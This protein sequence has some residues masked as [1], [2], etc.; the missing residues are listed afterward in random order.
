MIATVLLLG[1]LLAAQT[2]GFHAFLSTL[3]SLPVGERSAT[4]ATFLHGRPLPLVEDDSVLTFVWFGHA[5]SVYVNGALQEG[6][7]HPDK[8]ER[9]RCS[10]DSGLFYRRYTVPPDAMLEYQLVIDGKYCLDPGNMRTTAAGDY[11][12]SQAVMGRFRASVWTTDP[13]KVS[14]GTVDTLMFSPTD[15]LLAPRK[16]FVYRPHAPAPRG[17][18]AL[19]VVNDGGTALQ[20]LSLTAIADN[21]IAAGEVPPFIAVFVPAVDRVA[22]YRGLNEVRYLNAIADELVPMITKRYGASR[23]PFR[24]AMLGSSDGGHFAL[25]APLLRSD[26]FGL[27]AGQSPTI[28]R[29]LLAAL[30]SRSRHAPLPPRV[31]VFQQVGAYDIV[32]DEY[33]F[34]KQNQQFAMLL[35]RT[36]IRH[37]FVVSNDGHDWPSWRERVPEILRFLFKPL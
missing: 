33:H 30:E 9:V 7:R 31:R 32:S 19:L 18:Y 13:P 21:M 17:G 20:F 23:D 11:R 5:D 26:V 15:T 8:M 14:P 36:G 35:A 2:S 3:Q 1:G 27:A 4:V 25:L 6:W 22:E 28:D 34:L 12:N 29:D 10:G 24:H 37:R 16:V